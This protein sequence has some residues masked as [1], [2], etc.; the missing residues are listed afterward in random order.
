MLSAAVTLVLIFFFDSKNLREILFTEDGHLDGMVTR[1][2]ITRLLT[3]HFDH[4][5]ALYVPHSAQE[6]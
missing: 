3:S 1:R 4:A 5:A 6:R 2:D